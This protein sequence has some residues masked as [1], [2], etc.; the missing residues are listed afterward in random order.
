MVEGKARAAAEAI[1]KAQ[2]DLS[3]L[4]A[5]MTAAATVIGLPALFLLCRVATKVGAF[6]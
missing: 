2:P 6:G 3:D 1:G 4:K 5:A